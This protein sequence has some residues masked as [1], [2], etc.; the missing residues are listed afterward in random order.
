MKNLTR[1]FVSVMERW[2]PDP[3]VI[4][5]FLTLVTIVAALGATDYTITQAIDS[6]GDSYW[7]LLRFTA[8]MILILALGHVLANT[9]AVAALLQLVAK[10]IKT[11][12][13]AY[14]GLAIF[15]GLA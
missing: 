1:G 4:A 6:W 12:R 10:Q 2:M 8:Q 5:I 14:S 3:L 15:A 11:P 13:M 9:R 7:S